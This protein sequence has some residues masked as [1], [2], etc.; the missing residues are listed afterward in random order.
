[1][2]MSRL[3]EVLTDLRHWLQ[4]N[5]WQIQKIVRILYAFV[6]AIMLLW[7]LILLLGLALDVIAAQ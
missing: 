6:T 2:G 3:R 7:L 5:L 4:A 1:M